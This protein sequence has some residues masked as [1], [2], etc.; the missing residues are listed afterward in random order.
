MSRSGEAPKVNVPDDL[1]DILLEFTINYLLEQPPDIID[2]AVD[3]FKKL[4][5]NRR[6]APPKENAPASPDDSILSNDDGESYSANM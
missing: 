4:Q 6:A 3:F 1:R 5:E 2:Y